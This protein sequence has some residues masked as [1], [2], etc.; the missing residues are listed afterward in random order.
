[1]IKDGLPGWRQRD[2]SEKRNGCGTREANRR[3]EFYLGGK[4][5]G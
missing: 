3:I 1:M 4:K 5:N 2:G